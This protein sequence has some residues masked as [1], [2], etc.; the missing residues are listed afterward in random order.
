MDRN[1][2]S[3]NKTSQGD[4]EYRRPVVGADSI[5]DSGSR[6]LTVWCSL[7]DS[8]EQVMFEAGATVSPALSNQDLETRTVTASLDAWQQTLNGL[9]LPDI[10]A[11]VSQSR[12]LRLFPGDLHLPFV[13]TP[14][15]FESCLLLADRIGWSPRA[16]IVI[17]AA[18][19][20]AIPKT[21]QGRAPNPDEAVGFFQGM[22]A[23]QEGH[24]RPAQFPHVRVLRESGWQ[25][26]SLSPLKRS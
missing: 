26:A 18:V 5:S 24:P 13:N 20:T 9:D 12:P 6:L 21:E 22:V 3:S 25:F 17:L 7:S 1:E 15:D 19:R 8:D 14:D 4:G 2:T 11:A 23:G 10:V 16:L